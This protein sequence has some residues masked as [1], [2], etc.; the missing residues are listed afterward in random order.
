MLLVALSARGGYAN[1]AGNGQDDQS[2]GR[3]S[4]QGHQ[5]DHQGHYG[6]HQGNGS[7]G[8][9][10]HYG[11]HQPSRGGHHTRSPIA[12]RPPGGVTERATHGPRRAASPARV[13]V[14][15][16]VLH[17]PANALV[18]MAPAASSLSLD[19][20]AAPPKPGRS[21]A[22]GILARLGAS[23][24][25]SGSDNL[26]VPSLLAGAMGVV[27]VGLAAAMVWGHRRR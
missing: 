11:D 25:F 5:S 2:S 15:G 1:D 6:D 22:R 26:V 13:T 12:Q 14:A 18:D 27:L 16:L 10:G 4:H 19:A 3:A 21:G 9:H 17:K 7:D 20:S 23:L 8:R 24:S